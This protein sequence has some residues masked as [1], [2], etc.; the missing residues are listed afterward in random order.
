MDS[1]LVMDVEVAAGESTRRRG[2]GYLIAPGLVLTSAHVVP[3]PGATVTVSRVRGARGERGRH[4]ATV[5]WRGTPHARDDAALLRVDAPGARPP[6]PVPPVRWG[7]LVT[8]ASGT[9]CATTGLPWFVQLGAPDLLRLDGTVNRTD[10]SANN[11]H[12]MRLDE[13]AEARTGDGGRPFS[14]LSGLSGASLFCGDLLTAVVAQDFGALTYTRVEV[15]P[16]YV[17][18]SD[19]E[20][21]RIVEAHGLGTVPE[22]AEWQRLTTHRTGG[23]RPRTRPLASPAALLEAEH[24]VV[25]FQGRE[26]LLADLLRWCA[27]PGLG[28]RLLHGPGG[29]GKTRLALELTDRLERGGA[30]VVWPDADATAAD[31]TALGDTAVPLLVVVDYAET[32]VDQL[33]GLLKTLVRRPGTVPLRILLLAR[34]ADGDWW[35][36]A[37]RES[38]DTRDLLDGMPV[39]ALP[40]LVPGPGGRAGAYDAAVDALARALPRVRGHRYRKWDALA[41][42]VAAARGGGAAAPGADTALTLHMTALA[43][44]LDA[45]LIPGGPP[46]AS[47]PVERRLLDHESKYWEAAARRYGLAARETS[48]EDALAAAF[49]CGADDPFQG[50]RLLGRISALRPLGPEQHQAFAEWIAALYPPRDGGAWGALLPDRLA[51]FFVAERLT[52][53]ARLAGELL[54]GARDTA[55]GVTSAQA[56]RLLTVY[57]R[58]AAHPAVR[59][60]LDAPLCELC[61]RR[62]DVLERPAVDVATQAERPAP[63]VAALQR[64]ADAPAA[65]Y[66][67]LL[68]LAGHLPEQT[69]TLAP[70]AAGVTGRL[71]GVLRVR[72]ADD[73]AVLPELALTLRRL[74][75]RLGDAGEVG[76]AYAAA[77]EARRIYEGLAADDPAAYRPELAAVLH[78]LSVTAGRAGRRDEALEPARASVRLYRELA[79]GRPE[80]DDSWTY[81][82]HGLGALAFAEGNS[83]RPEAALAAVDEEVR[84][85]RPLAD[86]H[87]ETARAGLA[88][89][90]NNQAIWRKDCGHLDAALAASQEAV[91]RLRPLAEERPDAHL[92]GLAR[93][94]STLSDCLGRAGRP[95]KALEAAREALAIRRRLASGR[96][97]SSLADL[98]RSLNSLAIDL[99]DTGR[100]E[101]SLPYAAEAVDVLRQLADVEPAAY[102]HELANTLN[103]YANQLSDAGHVAEAAAAAQESADRYAALAEREP[104]VFTADLAMSLLTLAG[105]L[106]EAGKPGEALTAAEECVRLHRE[107]AARRPGTGEH[108]LASALNNLC[109]LLHRAG[110]EEEALAAVDEA[111]GL[112]RVLADRTA[113][114]PRA[115]PSLATALLNE[116]SCLLPLGR[117]EEAVRSAAEAVRLHR[118]LA[119]EDPVLHEPRYAVA[120]S[121]YWGVL[122]QAGRPAAALEAL[123]EAVAVRGRVAARSGGPQALRAYAQGLLTLG[124]LLSAAGHPQDAADALAKAATAHRHLAA[125]DAADATGGLALGLALRVACLLRLGLRADALPDAEEATRLLDGLARQ[126]DAQRP[127]LAE[128][129]CVLGGL[130]HDAGLPDAEEVLRRAARVSG[131]LPPEAGYDGLRSMSRSLLGTHLA[132]RGRLDEGIGHAREAVALA[133][134]PAGPLLAWTLVGLGRL[135]A[136]DP[137]TADEALDVCAEAVAVSEDPAGADPA[138]EESVLAVALAEH[139]LR[140]AAARRFADALAATA[141]A[142]TLCRNLTG[143]HA[144]ADREHLALALYAH[145]RTRLLA[146]ADLPAAR[147]AMREAAPLWERLAEEEPGLA[148]PYLAP[149]TDTRVRLDAA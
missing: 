79:A 57:A 85:R 25:P 144:A 117:T 32:R 87:G 103:T 54:G 121:G 132:E 123:R 118:D 62:G 40:P 23:R 89:A 17:L 35:R 136:L 115:R 80:T 46:G 133:R 16:A 38:R 77:C 6:W 98:A 94:V 86:V 84:I 59:G 52:G 138:E 21:R 92:P 24:A 74:T 95:H 116:V 102:G 143:R 114:A 43:D 69:H 11:R 90:L 30:A 142:V 145:A 134:G 68:R 53:N 124:Q 135:L 91:R 148:A 75:G 27:E 34:T 10:R 120:L 113:T 47:G 28:V 88:A 140:L 50:Q 13:R 128:C 64:I 22:P 93:A 19:P 119:R 3:G 149:V 129:L 45:A 29:Q 101:E 107:L 112:Q 83:G 7:R 137:R 109:L 8:H 110:R 48:L 63:L 97:G 78:N 81:V 65:T 37:R 31:L 55:D 72:A 66:D 67:D 70:L 122:S 100:T 131:T 73:P 26:D 14:P 105:R 99:G 4:P 51:E 104:D 127:L 108:E 12:L 96:S 56:A 130:L 2:S 41:R 20:F 125:G 39:T 60:T 111:I 15:V 1:D 146:D 61:V 5:L 139:G 58:A 44:L 18:L 36:A 71:A 9:P 42:Q 49:L 147:E 106:E 141:R 82:A 33:T 76:R 126:D